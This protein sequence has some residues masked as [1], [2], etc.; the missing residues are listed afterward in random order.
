MQVIGGYSAQQQQA[1][2]AKHDDNDNDSRTHST[3]MS[4][5]TAATETAKAAAQVSTLPQ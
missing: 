2:A 5:D 4:E 3:M 1:E